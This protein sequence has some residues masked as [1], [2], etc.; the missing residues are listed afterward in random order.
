[1]KAERECIEKD[2]YEFFDELLR[3]QGIEDVPLIYNNE[4]GVRPKS[5]FLSLEFRSVV[6]LGMPEKSLVRLEEG[7]DIQ[8]IT[9]HMRQHMTMHGFG[10]RGVAALEIIKA[11]LNVD[12]WIDKL[13]KRKMVIPQTMETVERPRNFETSREKGALFDFDLTYQR[14]TEVN[15]GYIEKVQFNPNF[16]R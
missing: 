3:S 15:P 7:K 1:M 9:Q 5:P 8:R 10:E 4:N 11:Q 12:S 16:I 14:I 13:R 6:S 2:L